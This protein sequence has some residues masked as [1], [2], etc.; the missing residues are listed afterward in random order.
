MKQDNVDR[1]RSCCFRGCRRGTIGGRCSFASRVAWQ[2]GTVDI[3]FLQH[4]SVYRVYEN[5]VHG[6]DLFSR[7]TC[8]VTRGIYARVA[9]VLDYWIVWIERNIASISW[10]CTFC[11]ISITIFN[12][13]NITMN[14]GT[15]N[16]RIIP[17]TLILVQHNTNSKHNPQP[18]IDKY[19]WPQQL[20][21]G[22]RSII[23][24]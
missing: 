4:G 9:Q 21:E 20:P 8:G 13:E 14:F 1:T 2:T 10:W 19:K 15:Q 22:K 11:S 7:T 3:L 18:C 16:Q 12:L 17:N 23:N 6:P 5:T 24:I